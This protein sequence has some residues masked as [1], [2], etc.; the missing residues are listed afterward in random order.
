MRE[1]D[2][3]ELADGVLGLLVRRRHDRDLA[4]GIEYEP[5]AVAEARRRDRIVERAGDV[6]VG[7]ARAVADIEH[8]GVGGG[9]RDGARGGAEPTSGPR[10]S[11]MMR[12]I[13]GG[14]GAR[15]AFARSTNCATVI[16]A[17][18]GLK[19]RS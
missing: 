14:L 7:E 4:L 18:I 8:L 9:L 16:S 3:R 17:S 10:F 2:R 6:A 12:A 13:V 5:A 11:S 1:A 19:R 15:S